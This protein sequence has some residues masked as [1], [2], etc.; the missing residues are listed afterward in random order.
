MSQSTLCTSS[1]ERI[2]RWG[3]QVQQN[4]GLYKSALEKWLTNYLMEHGKKTRRNYVYAQLWSKAYPLSKGMPISS[5]HS[6]KILLRLPMQKP[7]SYFIT[8]GGCN[9]TKG[10]TF[11]RIKTI[12]R[13]QPCHQNAK[14]R[15]TIIDPVSSKYHL[16]FTTF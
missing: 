16:H 10:T 1:I 8:W 9:Q 2:L 13:K 6:S 12:V 3:K 5:E 14:E 4:H 11:S 15:W 7:S